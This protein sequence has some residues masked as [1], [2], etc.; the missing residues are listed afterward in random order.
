MAGEESIKQGSFPDEERLQ[1][2]KHLESIAEGAGLPIPNRIAANA[3]ALYEAPAG[4]PLGEFDFQPKNNN[5]GNRFALW[6]LNTYKLALHDDGLFYGLNESTRGDWEIDAREKKLARVSLGQWRPKGPRE[7]PRT[8]S[9]PVKMYLKQIEGVELLR[10]DEEVELAQ[11]IEA[12][13]YAVQKLEGGKANQWG[14]K[15]K[16]SQ[17]RNYAELA[18]IGKDAFDRLEAANLRLVVSIAKGYTGKGLPLLDLIQEGNIALRH[19][20]EKFD[21]KLG[22]KFSTYATRWIKQAIDRA[23]GEQSRTISISKYGREKLVKVLNEES[24]FEKLGIYDISIEE[25]AEATGVD[26]DDAKALIENHLRGTASL[27]APVNFEEDGGAVL[28]DLIE[29]VDAETAESA[30]IELDEKRTV[31]RV[32]REASEIAQATKKNGSKS[33][34]SRHELMKTRFGIEDG[35]VKTL[36]ETGRIHGVSRGIVA[37]AEKVILG[38]MRD[39]EEFRR[40]LLGD[41]S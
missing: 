25:L 39:E 11:A 36:D 5:D 8:F 32:L 30:Q 19:A 38:L 23:L 27:D 22:F 26:P 4:T 16:N 40:A 7:L 12:G 35:I 24:E 14:S 20:I 29:S 9:D 3:E 15:L 10:A 6:T 31:R 37:A 17:R 41:D 21:Y 1:R 2:L 34:Y 33:S 18:L 28:G 13:L